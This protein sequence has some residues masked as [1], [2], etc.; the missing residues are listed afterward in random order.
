MK[1]EGYTDSLPY[2]RDIDGLRAIAILAVLFYHTDWPFFKGGYMGVDIFFVL[3]GFLITS[4]V[5][6]DIDKGSFTLIG[7]WERR[8]RRILPALLAVLAFAL[9]SGWFLL[10]PGDY[11]LLGQQLMAQTV[12]SSNI[13]F[14]FQ[15]GYFDPPSQSKI[16]LH[17]W[18]LAVEEQFYLFFPVVLAFLVRTKLR[19]PLYLLVGLVLSYFIG[20]WGINYYP[21]SSFYLLPGR[22]WELLLGSLIVFTPAVQW[23]RWEKEII[24]LV[25]LFFILGA[26]IVF[27]DGTSSDWLAALPPCLGV[28]LIIWSGKETAPSITHRVLSTPVIAGIGVIS[29]SLYLW[30]WPFFVYARYLTLSPPGNGS[31]MLVMIGTVIVAFLSWAFIETPVRRKKFLQTRSGLFSTLLSLLLV[32]GLA[33]G[34]VSC[35]KGVSS[36]FSPK[37]ARYAAG[38]DD[39]NALSAQCFMEGRSPS[40]QKGFCSVGKATSAPVFLAFGDSDMNS[41][42]PML[43]QVAK[44]HRVSGLAAAYASCPPFFDVVPLVPPKFSNCRAFNNAALE[45]ISKNHIRHVILAARWP[46]YSRYLVAGKQPDSALVVRNMKVFNQG[47]VQMVGKIRKAGADVW[48]VRS[49]PEYPFD[50]PR[51]LA[52][53][54]ITGGDVHGVG[55]TFSDYKSL[56]ADVDPVFRALQK[57]YGVRF[58]DPT[59]YLCTHKG[60]CRTEE[61]GR[62]LYKDSDHLSTFGVMKLQNIF[63]GALR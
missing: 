61:D 22:V 27:K 40:R 1:P 34:V 19:V 44:A 2:R 41:L 16:L 32:M 17:T 35:L 20:L 37:V 23:T 8:V 47:L 21:S 58:I 29:Y 57:K 9:V 26:M 51:Q 18:S 54:L 39:G 11:A 48:I 12:F 49:P 25:G 55:Q 52:R 50:V 6:K 56:Q 4:L 38:A 10:L 43:D 42:I 7:F 28:A 30:H 46:V 24:A 33:G 3:S 45:A 13:L 60:F 14:F 36:R 59:D 5:I 53:T 62:S 31:M 15:S 63:D